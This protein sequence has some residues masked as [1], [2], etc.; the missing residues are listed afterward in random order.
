M[1]FIAYLI[2]A[3]G[4]VLLI[5]C[6]TTYAPPPVSSQNPNYIIGPGDTLEIFVWRNP[7]VSRSVPVR[8]DGKISTPLV[9]D[10]VAAGK[11]PTQLARDLERA[12][13]DNAASR[14]NER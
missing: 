5:G 10:M 13:A 14:G 7:E 1:R 6:A 12:Q 4:S 3:L 11:T 2:L 9:E 8:P